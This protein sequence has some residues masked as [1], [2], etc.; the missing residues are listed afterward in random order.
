MSCWF[1][2][3]TPRLLSLAA[4]ARVWLV[5]AQLTPI[6]RQAAARPLTSRH[7]GANI[8][9]FSSGSMAREPS[10]ISSPPAADSDCLHPGNPPMQLLFVRR[11][12][13]HVSGSGVKSARVITA[14]S[15]TPHSTTDHRST[16]CP[17][18]LGEERRDVVS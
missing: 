11:K 5:S 6:A 14:F 18:A 15:D 16:G 12:T 17:L 3:A 8:L 1:I 4:S 9:A 7:K 13:E 2:M 10:I